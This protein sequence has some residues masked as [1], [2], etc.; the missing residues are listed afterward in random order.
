M[1]KNMHKEKL[2][3][4]ISNNGDANEL[5]NND[6]NFVGAQHMNL[7]CLRQQSNDN[8]PFQFSIGIIM[9]AF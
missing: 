9:H 3:H 6:N 7:E 8:V 5:N 1:M 2:L 4:G